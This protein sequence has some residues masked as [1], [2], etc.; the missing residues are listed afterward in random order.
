MFSFFHRTP[1]IEMDCFINDCYVYENVP[2]VHAHK[3]YP[4]WWLDLPLGIK[5]NF[6]FSL[7]SANQHNTG[8][9]DSIL[10]NNNMKNCYGFTEFYKRGAV[11]ESWADIKFKVGLAGYKFFCSHSELPT[12][13]DTSQRGTGFKDYHHAKLNNPWLFEVKEDVKFIFMAATWNM[14]NNDFI[15]PP[16]ISN[17]RLANVGHINIFIPRK[18]FEFEIGI[19]QPLVHLIPLS[20]KK[21]KITNHII[22]NDEYKKKYSAVSSSF[23]GWRKKMELILKRNNREKEKCPFS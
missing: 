2:I 7:V 10:Q 13:H 5:R 6:D 1:K 8:V 21:L 4:Q 14:E 16:G 19:G 17:F 9:M 12:K 20:D 22:S 18:S 15:I 23:Y 3:T 11:I